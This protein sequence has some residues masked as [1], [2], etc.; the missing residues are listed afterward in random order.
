LIVLRGD[1]TIASPTTSTPPSAAAIVIAA[2]TIEED[3]E[4]ESESIL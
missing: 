1:V 3:H 2:N 4:G